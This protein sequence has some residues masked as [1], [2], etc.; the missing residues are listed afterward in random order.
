MAEY[1]T[2]MGQQ[3]DRARASSKFAG[4]TALPADLIATLK[5]TEFQGYETLEADGCRVVALLRD[6][7]PVDAIAAGDEALVLLDR[8]PFYA[9]SGGQ[10]GDTGVLVGGAWRQL[11]GARHA[12]SSPAPSTATSAGSPAAR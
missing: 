3:R 5:H 8:T 2:L 6:G 7:K 1:E 11:R 12:S 9:E 4:G 10:V